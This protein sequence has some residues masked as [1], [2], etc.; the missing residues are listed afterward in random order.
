[1]KNFDKVYEAAAERYGL[2][3]VE[4][5]AELGINRKQFS[6]ILHRYESSIM[7]QRHTTITQRRSRSSAA[8]QSYT[9]MV[10]WPCTTLPL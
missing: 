6:G 9:A 8:M 4:D 7:F 10:F 5:A 2:I 1:M 3:T